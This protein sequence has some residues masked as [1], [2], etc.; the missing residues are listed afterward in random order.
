MEHSRTKSKNLQ[1]QI[2]NL[3]GKLYHSSSDDHDDIGTFGSSS[4]TTNHAVNKGDNNNIALLWSETENV[5]K[6]LQTEKDRRIMLET[7]LRTLQLSL[8]RETETQIIGITN[9]EI[10]E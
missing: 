5:S 7:S 6:E 4:T 2:S 9:I 8:N 3:N 10:N 1:A